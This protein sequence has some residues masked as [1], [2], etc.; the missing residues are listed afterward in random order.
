MLTDLCLIYLF[1]W[2]IYVIYRYVK[3]KKNDKLK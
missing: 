2:C 3:W 1:F